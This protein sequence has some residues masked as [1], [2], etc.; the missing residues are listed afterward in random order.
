[1][2]AH[3]TT[4]IAEINDRFR[5]KGGDPLGRTVFTQQVAAMPPQ[6]RV[7]IKR[8]VRLF[9]NFNEENDPCGEHDFGSIDYQ[10]ETYFWKFEYYDENY[11]YTSEDPSDL[12]KT[13]RVLTIMHSSEY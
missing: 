3:T 9:D 4:T 1:M 13:R 12:A 10:G 8:L 7:S 5:Q 2:T 11:E 6:E